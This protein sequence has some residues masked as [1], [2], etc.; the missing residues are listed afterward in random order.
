[1][2]EI[3]GRQETAAARPLQRQM[4]ASKSSDGVPR[5][6]GEASSFQEFEEQCLVYE[7]SVEYHKRYMVAPRVIA[8]LQG[9][10][11]KVITGKP[12]DWVSYSGGLRELLNTL[13][14]SLGK[15]QV[16]EVAD[17]LNK[18][19]RGSRRKSGE[20]MGDYIV[21]KTEAYLRAQQ[22]L[23]RVLPQYSQGQ[24]QWRSNASHNGGSRRSSWDS[25]SA[26]ATTEN[27]EANAETREE[28]T[29]ET[30]T[31]GSDWN[32]SQ[33][34]GG[35]WSSWYSYRDPWSHSWAWQTGPDYRSSASQGS[36][37]ALEEIIP[38]FVQGWFLLNDAGLTPGER[39]MIHTAVQGD[40]GVHRIAQELR[41]QWDENSIRKREGS[42]RGQTSYLGDGFD[43]FDDEGDAMEQGFEMDD[44]TAEGQALVSEAEEEAQEALA[45][46]ERGRRTLRDARTRQHQ[47]R[48][49]RQYHKL[50][51]ASTSGKPSSLG[52]SSS[53]RTSPA[54]SSDDSRMT[55]L[56][57]GKVG[58]RAANCPQKVQTAATLQ[59]TNDDESAPF[60]C[61]SEMAYSLEDTENLMTTQE[62]VKQGYGVL[63]GG[64]TRTIGSVTALQRVLDLNQKAYGED[65]VLSVDPELRPTFAFGNSSKE[66]C[67]STIELGLSAGSKQ[68][69]LSVHTLDCGDGPVLLS[70]AT[71]RT[72][73]TVLDFQNDLV[74][75]RNLDCNKVVP[76]KRSRTGHQ[77]L[78][79]TSDIFQ[80]AREAKCAIPSLASYIS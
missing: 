33:W 26:E 66:K 2:G 52:S 60:I 50:P 65:R 14:A 32:W 63:D 18:Y 80:D 7:Q 22:A 67:S 54:G 37:G 3:Q 11:R 79:L 27:L 25:G 38:D 73:G 43:E 16:S 78:S 74:C 69:K 46:I 36:S 53:Y 1:M 68:G 29:E 5:W 61:F 45:A 4:S 62:A 41:N 49:A 47:V 6:N 28:G 44:L 64:A 40:Y 48:M 55:C 59:E 76:L 21:R 56:K 34:Q 58:H 17:F 10:A 39:N 8:E 57:C 9:T 19:F 15:P 35:Y 24:G 12:A 30:T 13:R 31:A 42:Q 51:A 72:L 20:T 77:L 71:L 75:F 70:V 23:Q